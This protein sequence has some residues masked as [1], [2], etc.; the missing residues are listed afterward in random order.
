MSKKGPRLRTIAGG[1][2]ATART[3]V[4]EVRAFD[5][6]TTAMQ[7]SVKGLREAQGTTRAVSVATAHDLL[8]DHRVQLLRAIRKDQPESVAALA[9]IVGRT[10]ESVKADLDALAR[11]GVVTLENPTAKSQVRVPRV[12][13]TGQLFND[14]ADPE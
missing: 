2:A 12:A 14:P 5:D 3:L 8:T 11:V 13:P 4:L 6:P 7:A 10:P 1:G 9:R